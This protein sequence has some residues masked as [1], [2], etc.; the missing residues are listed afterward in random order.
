MMKR[1]LA[2]VMIFFVWHTWVFAQSVPWPAAPEIAA[3]AYMVKD[4]QSGKVLAEKNPDVSIEPASL[5]QLMTVYLTFQSLQN[6]SI[7]PEQRF[8]VSDKA[9]RNEGTRMFLHA[10]QQVSIADLV[11]GLAVQSGNDAAVTL[12]EGISGS[13]K[14]FVA[15]MNAQ[16]ARLG[17]NKT[18]FENSTGLSA[19][20]QLT[21]VHDL[22]LL[23]QAL[24]RDFPADYSVFSKKTFTYNGITEPNRNLLLFRD[25]SVNGMKAAYSDIAGYSLIAT[26]KFGDRQILSI[27]V[28]AVS[29]EARATES[30][31][32]LNY[33]LKHFTTRKLYQA[34]SKLA[35]AQ[36]YGGERETVAIGAAQ[37]IYLTVPRAYQGSIRLTLTTH[38]PIAAPVEAG[39]TLGVLQAASA[40][41]EIWLETPLVALEDNLPKGM[42]QRLRYRI[43]RLFRSIFSE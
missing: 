29:P 3:T 8:T 25:N 2:A 4:L 28:G 35:Q 17:M 30:R 12:A 39:Q 7:K 21:T 22:S 36:V 41:G 43:V 32:L 5:A 18:L 38:E 40:Q 15:R 14:A 20:K 34:G 9:W 37:E 6:G 27:V 13:E 31:K 26:G 23:A 19:A 33:A 1:C 10:G 24:M 16:A 42:M 11:Q